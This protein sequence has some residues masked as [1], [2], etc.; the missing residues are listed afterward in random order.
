M[1]LFD[2]HPAATGAGSTAAVAKLLGL[3]VLLVLD[4]ARMAQSAAAM[5]Y[6]YAR[7]DPE[8]NVVGVIANNVGSASHAAP[9]QGGHRVQAGL[10]VVGCLPRNPDL[11]LPERHLGLVPTDEERLASDY[12]ARLSA[13]VEEHVDLDVVERTG[14]QAAPADG[15]AL[16]P[17]GPRGQRRRAPTS[18]SPRDEAFCFYYQ[19]N[20]DLLEACGARLVPFS[21]LGDGALPAG[22]RRRVSGRRLP[23][24]LRRAPG[25]EP[26]RCWRPFA[27][28][29]GG[30]P[31]Y[32]ECGGLMYL[33]RTPGRP[34]RGMA[35]KLVG[36][37]P[38][39]A[40]DARTAP[41]PRL[42]RGARLGRGA[43]LLGTGRAG[44]RPRVPLVEP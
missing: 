41:C 33:C 21:P 44:A 17:A 6:G 24:A 26:R 2:G 5:A 11:V 23:R 39:N 25:G 30:L 14:G 16:G 36:L 27:A 12:F 8:L 34:R 42:R 37:V 38:A 28:H 43:L 7:L 35:P 31:I 15:G 22:L 29:G 10:P 40:V 32:A 20:L 4:V 9:G 3:P 13:H 19:D 1:G 18:P